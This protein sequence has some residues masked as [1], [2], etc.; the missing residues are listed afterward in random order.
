MDS[1]SGRF[2]ARLFA[3]LHL[4]AGLL[5]A[6]GVF[7]G[8]PV[9]RAFV[10]VPSA[11]LVIGHAVVA[12]GLFSG[13]PWGRIAA[14]WFSRLALLAG[15]AAVVALLW[16]MAFLAKVHGP[17]GMG[18]VVLF[19]MVLALIVPYLV[20]LPLVE[21][22]WLLRATT[23][24]RHFWRFLFGLT[25]VVL[26]ALGTGRVY[27]GGTSTSLMVLTAWQ[28]GTLET[29]AFGATREQARTRLGPVFATVQVDEVTEV[30]P[31]APGVLAPLSFAIARD[32]VEARHGDALVYLTPDELRAARLYDAAYGSAELGFG[33]GLDLDAART[34]ARQRLGLEPGAQ[35]GLRRARFTR[36]SSPPAP[37]RA[38]LVQEL[39]DGARE[40]AMYLARIT[41]ETGRL[42][43]Q[44]RPETGVDLDD[45]NWPRHAGVTWFLAE[46]AAT[47]RDPAL[48]AATARASRHLLQDGLSKCGAETCVADGN[49]ADVGS[50][51]MTLLALSAVA[52]VDATSASLQREVRRSLARFLLSQQRPDGE[53]AH[54]FDRTRGKAIDIQLPYYT[55]EAALALVT[56]AEDLAEPELY[57]A[58][59]RALSYLATRGW[60][61]PLASYWLAEEHWTC[62]AS[63][64]LLRAKRP[65]AEGQGLCRRWLE[66][67]RGLLWRSE[68]PAADLLGSFSVVPFV[69]PRL[70][71]AAS[72]SEAAIAYLDTVRLGDDEDV[73]TRAQVE[74][75]LRLLLRHQFKPVDAYALRD[76]A[77]MMGAIPAS[78]VDRDVRI[79]YVQHAG[80]AFLRFAE[81]LRRTP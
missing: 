8:L 17:I 14:L 43:Y 30:G 59:G 74:P 73:A 38:S 70:T 62:Q 63:A 39:H 26:F 34:L 24:R 71:P 6:F 46:A 48:L 36:V 72:R 78:T 21:V 51:A 12:V 60:S 56:V 27:A 58:A 16:S 68:A 9:R 10:D 22:A 19:A 76:P 15:V 28:Q 18:G 11:A 66:M 75:A 7:R 57:A 4:I 45:Y 65:H 81:V 55:G 33:L 31:L 53:F 23:A 52:R 41:G 20:V 54:Q 49:I 77:L 40:A 80:M 42:R 3:T 35:I 79:D 25:L 69:A 1:S 5:L 67:Q 64:A 29:Q 13:R 61:F 50:S 2:L 37:R 32:G 44:V 47:Y